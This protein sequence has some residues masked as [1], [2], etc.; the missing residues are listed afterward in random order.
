MRS[1]LIFEVEHGNTTDPL[2]AFVED[3]LPPDQPVNR[4][5]FGDGSLV[6]LDVAVKVDLPECF[7]LDSG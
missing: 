1:L 5:Y 7:V 2:Q 3:M 4:D 6:L